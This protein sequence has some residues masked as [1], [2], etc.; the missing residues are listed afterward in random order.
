MNWV[1]AYLLV[2]FVLSWIATRAGFVS[3]L[4]WRWELAATVLWPLAAIVGIIEVENERK[5]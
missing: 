2:G 4:D 1:L 3:K 5:K